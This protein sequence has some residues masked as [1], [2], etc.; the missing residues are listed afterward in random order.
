[1]WF[2]GE[3]SRPVILLN[4]IIEIFNIFPGERVRRRAEIEF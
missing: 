1:M 3:H 4:E 2:I